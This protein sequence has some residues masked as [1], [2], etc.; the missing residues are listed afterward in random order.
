MPVENVDSSFEKS[1]NFGAKIILAREG[2]CW[3][4]RY[5]Q[6]QDLLV[7]NAHLPPP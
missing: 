2:T 7:T 3:E 4:D 5:R 1:L 6:I